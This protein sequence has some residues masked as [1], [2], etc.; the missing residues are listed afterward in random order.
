MRTSDLS[1]CKLD[2]ELEFGDDYDD[3]KN[4]IAG[5]LRL[6]KASK[7][8]DSLLEVQQK[9]RGHADPAV[10]YD[11]EDFLQPKTQWMSGLTKIPMPAGRTD[12]FESLLSP[13]T[14]V[15]YTDE[16]VPMT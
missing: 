10:R 14:L 4:L 15:H 5:D 13:N 3:V 2:L 6:S 7:V 9:V 11:K 12:P 8:R 1:R 16:G